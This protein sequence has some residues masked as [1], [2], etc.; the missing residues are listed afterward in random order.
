MKHRL[1][2]PLFAV[3]VLALAA[4]TGAAFAGGNGNGGSTSAGNSAS[5]PGHQDQTAP[6]PAAAAAADAT[7]AAKTDKVADK[8]A[9]KAAKADT[10]AKAS[11]GNSAHTSSS[12]QTSSSVQTSSSTQTS[13]SVKASAQSSTSPC[14][15]PATGG[16]NSHGVKP[17]NTTQHNTCAAA[18]SDKTKLYGN[19][20]TAGQ[21]ATHAGYGSAALHGPGNSQPHKTSPCPGKHEVDVHALKHKAGTCGSVLAVVTPTVKVE[22]TCTTIT[23]TVTERVLAA[24]TK[25][26]GKSA[27]HASVHGKAHANQA[28]YVTVIKTL[29]VPTGANC[30][31]TQPT[32]VSTQVVSTSTVTPAAAVQATAAATPAASASAPV[33][34]AT[35]ATGAVQG[36]VVALK[37]TKAAKTKPAGGVLGATTRLGHTVS[38]GRLPFTGLPLWIFAL[39]AAGLIGVGAAA[40]HTASRRI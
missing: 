24:D 20:K 1:T 36:A 25:V 19:G 16:D 2:V 8:T 28:N 27:L 4:F 11:N 38:S 18:S 29:S 21:I 9:D 15:N 6:A 3:L 5:A 23:R 33:A 35:P 30:A 31:S 39:V 12:A 40:R 7:P 37:P 26:R 32:V 10:S 13:S 34:T 22:A 17:S 14:A